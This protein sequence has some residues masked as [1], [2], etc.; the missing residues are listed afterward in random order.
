MIQKV[1]AG[2]PRSG[3]STACKVIINGSNISYI[4][5]DS[6]I[7]TLY[8]VFPDLKI[9]HFLDSQEVSRKIAPFIKSFTKHLKFE[10]IDFIIDAY[11]LFPIDVA[12][13]EIE[14]I[15]FYFFGYPH[16]DIERKLGHIRQFSDPGSWIDDLSDLDLRQI[17]E[18]YKHESLIMKEQCLKYNLP[19]IDM[20]NNFT[21]SLD[22]AIKT[23]TY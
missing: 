19:F 13:N 3:K 23:L 10:H 15:D 20:S 18:K 17:I 12:K 14:G 4:P 16:V 22:A 1:I 7:S 21:A 11:Q 2:I 9:S 8:D 6:I 5:F